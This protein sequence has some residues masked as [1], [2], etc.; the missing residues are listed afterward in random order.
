M[1]VAAVLAA[2]LA[3]AGVAG[4]G[5][6]RLAVPVVRQAPE[7]CGPAALVMVMR[8]YGADSATAAE[9]DRAYDPVLRGSLI[10]D[11]AAAA[12]RA[13]FAAEVT[14][15]PEDSLRALVARGIPPILL[16]GR[17][18]GPL[19]V[20]HYGVLVGWDP[21]R[22]RYAVNDG[23]PATR[24]MARADLMGRWRAAGSLALV[25]RRSAP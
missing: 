18:V 12:R 9:A 21:G 20:R 5:A 15:M 24:T 22:G 6:A 4:P 17:G 8:F 13:G 19:T 3:T 1:R 10:T 25:L 23:G 2:A 16:Y 11:L 7:R 14:E